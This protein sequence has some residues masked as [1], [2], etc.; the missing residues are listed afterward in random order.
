[1]SIRAVAA[2]P[3]ERPF[4]PTVDS[5]WIVQSDETEKDEANGS[6]VGSSTTKITALLVYK[7][8]LPDG[9]RI[10]YERTNSSYE[11]DADDPAAARAALAALQGL[12]LQAVTDLSGKPLRV[13]NLPGL[14]AALQKMVDGVTGTVADPQTAAAARTMMADLAKTDEKDAAEHNLGK[15]PALALGQNSSLALGETR[16][17]TVEEAV[18]GAT[19]LQKTVT[20]TLLN[21]TPDGNRRYELDEVVDP[22]SMRAMLVA[23]LSKLDTSNP[24]V[25]EQIDQAKKMTISQEHRTQIEVS[26]G[27]ARSLHIGIGDHQA[28]SGCR[29]AAHDRQRRYR[30][31]CALKHR[32]GL[33]TLTMYERIGHE[34]RRPS[35]FSWRIRYAF[36]HKGVEPEFRHVRFA[37]VETIRALSEQHFVPIVTDGDTVVHDSWNI[38]CYLEDRFPDAPSL[39]PGGERGNAR[40]I[41]HWADQTLGAAIRRLI[42]A[43]FIRC[44][45]A[46]D[47][48][49]YRS[50]REATFGC[51]L[52][53][54]CADRPR[55]LAE[56]AVITAPL[57]RTLT[58]QPYVTGAAPG[59][60][61]YV[62]FSMF[63]YARLGSPHEFLGEGTAL[64][65]WRDS[66]AGMFGQLGD[67]YPAYPS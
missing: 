33:M 34:G 58:E 27:M 44:L 30:L 24:G 26:D 53:D 13:E 63:Q 52:E 11:G 41:N 16:R 42:A 64:R 59:Y 51:S 10:T 37:D 39:F 5:R 31:F 3:S 43:D 65:R 29:V 12:T 67:R 14:R 2:D 22:D 21:V 60:A 50:S 15:L 48:A 38:A 20:L 61:D 36:A 17:Q 28:F 66:L 32:I 1:M 56:F 46:G 49:Y 54:Y 25:Q 8:K 23:Y 47:R 18:P 57:E 55:W 35:P 6:V 62:V 19:P 7:E 40:L 45:D 9:Y 4:N